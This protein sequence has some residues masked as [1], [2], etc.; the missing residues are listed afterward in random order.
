LVDA[1]DGSFPFRSR[2]RRSF[3]VLPIG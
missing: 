1:R 3:E 2:L